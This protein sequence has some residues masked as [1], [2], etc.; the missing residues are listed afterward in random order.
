MK[1]LAFMSLAMVSVLFLAARMAERTNG[2]IS[3]SD[4]AEPGDRRADVPNWLPFLTAA[5]FS[6][7]FWLLASNMDHPI[8]P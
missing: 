8:E 5:L 2:G 6:M 7:G 3:R 4:A 1:L